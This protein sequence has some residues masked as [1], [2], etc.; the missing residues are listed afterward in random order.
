MRT[1]RPR[2]SRAMAFIVVAREPVHNRGRG[3]RPG[4]AAS[5][6]KRRFTLDKLQPAGLA[7]GPVYKGMGRHNRCLPRSNR[8]GSCH[9]GF[10]PDARS[11][12]L[13]AG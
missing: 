10:L 3:A 7:S 6:R 8:T 12:T 2:I 13:L 9:G 5:G 4:S 11:L 1:V